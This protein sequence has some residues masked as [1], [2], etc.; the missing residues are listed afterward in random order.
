LAYVEDT[1]EVHYAP[2]KWN[3]HVDS[4][5]KCPDLRS[6]VLFAVEK[7]PDA[8]LDEVSDFV[9]NLHQLLGEDVASSPSS[10]SRIL[11]ANGLTRKVLETASITRNELD[12]ARWVLDQWDIPCAR[13]FTWMRR[14]AADCPPTGSGLDHCVGIEPSVT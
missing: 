7:C 11:A 13:E 10:V 1:G 9:T 4:F 2:E 6:A 5:W 12:R 8:F 3:T 14:T